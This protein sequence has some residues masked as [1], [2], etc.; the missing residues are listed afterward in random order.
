MT[1]DTVR[2]AQSRSFREAASS[3]GSTLKSYF[4]M[5]RQTTSCTSNLKDVELGRFF[6]HFVSVGALAGGVCMVSLAVFHTV[7]LSMG[8]VAIPCA[9]TFLGVTYY[10]ESRDFESDEAIQ[11]LHAKASLMSLESIVQTYG[12]NDM[13]RLGILSTDE[14]ASK[15]RAH[16]KGKCLNDVIHHY[17]K[18]MLQLTRCTSRFQYYVP[19]PKEHAALWREETASIH[20]EQIFKTYPLEKLQKYSLVDAREIECIKK[21]KRDYDEIKAQHDQKISQIEQKF[22]TDT[23]SHNENFERECLR[24]SQ[25]YR[26]HSVVKELQGFEMHYTKERLKI[27]EQQSKSISEARSRFDRTLVTSLSGPVREYSRLSAAD[28]VIYDRCKQAFQRD[29]AEARGIAYQRI[30]EIN[31]QRHDRLLFLNAEESRLKRERTQAEEVAKKRY[32]EGIRGFVQQKEA[33]MKPIESCLQETAGDCDR[34]YRAYL[35]IS[36]KNYS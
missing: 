17:E 15:Y 18:T 36:S 25:I 5:Q 24:V 3:W 16:I 10:K 33:S 14:F 6:Y 32:E 34:R 21:L 11:K 35:R 2:G 22:K 1:L 12:W 20:C 13:L 30:D 27:Q 31:K 26:D 28:K 7:S 29:E 23:K 8:L 9:L 19:L 4:W